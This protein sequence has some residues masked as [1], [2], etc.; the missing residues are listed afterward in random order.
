MMIYI[1]YLKR[2]IYTFL[3]KERY[4][5]NS[6][7]DFRQDEESETTRTDIYKFIERAMQSG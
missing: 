5:A 3:D 7:Q 4:P 1:S 6:R 2:E